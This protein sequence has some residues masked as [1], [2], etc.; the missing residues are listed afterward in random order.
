MKRLIPFLFLLL[1]STA[2]A[3]TGLNKMKK[4]IA[5]LV[6]NVLLISS[7]AFAAT[8]YAAASGGGGAASC[9]DSG[10]N[11][12]TL[13]RAVVVASTGTNTI[14][15]GAGTYSISTEL[16]LGSGNTGA[17]LTFTCATADGCT[18][19]SSGT[20]QVVDIE[21]TMVSGTITFDD[22]TIDDGTGSDYGIRNQSPEVNVVFKNGTC[23]NSDATAGNCLNWV[24]DTTNKISLTTGEDTVTNIKTGATTNV[25]IAQKIVPAAN[26]TVNKIAFKLQRKCGNNNHNCDSFVSGESWDYRNAETLTYTIETDNAGAPSGTPVTNG[27]A[28]T[29]RAFDT[30]YKSD[31]WTPASF[32]S[33][34]SL[35][36]GTTYWLVL[37]G[38]YTASAS[39]YITASTDTGD[40]YASGDC[41]TFDNTN[42]TGCAAG[43]DLLFSIDRDHTRTLTVQDSTFNTRS[44]TMVVGWSGSVTVQ[45]NT[46]TST[47]SG[48]LA[49]SGNGYGTVVDS[50]MDHVLFEDNVV[51]V[52]NSGS[53]MLSF[54]TT[55]A[56]SYLETIM[57]TGNS[58]TTSVFM[59]PL[60]F[61]RR[62]MIKDNNLTFSYNGNNPWQVGREVDGADPQE[63]NENPFEQIV[64]TDNTFTFSAASH[65]HLFGIFIGGENGIFRNNTI[66]APGTGG[67]GIV[68]KA[69]NWMIDHNSFYGVSPGIGVLGTNNSSITNNTIYCSASTTDGCL[70]VRTHQNN[71][72]GGKHGLPINVYLSDNVVHMTDA[73]NAAY[74]WGT[75]TDTGPG[76][77]TQYWSVVSDNN[78]YWAPN[79]STRQAT[80]NTPSNTEDVTVAEGIAVVQSSFQSSN[81][82]YA[83]SLSRYNDLNSYF[84][85]PAL[86]DPANGNFRSSNSTVKNGGSV[87]NTSIGSYQSSGG[88]KWIG[89]G[90]S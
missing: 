10:A 19:T 85:D 3:A 9:V 70:L 56:T 78:V 60:S 90:V 15:C 35:T 49:L 38:S 51:S 53:L 33:N 14:E 88:R 62:M 55:F 73:T 12:C 48:I 81:Y 46:L 67:W 22:I 34:V 59:Q 16:S 83:T 57:V 18:W 52:S 77:T 13:A 28:T 41:A 63:L 82:S 79:N 40:G 26:I 21:T 44:N 27:T 1:T 69:D 84:L 75:T 61:V 72:Y 32:A 71:V 65:N 37:T 36:S 17:N 50:Q 68:L 42:W 4:L 29:I 87:P 24:I 86:A 47:A 64:I 2:F 58:G 39:N 20:G 25:K 6:L 89:R 45:R 7:T 54:G 31:Q 5:L 8:Y 43:T 74:D 76:R 30:E 11:V 23:N 66:F 80:L